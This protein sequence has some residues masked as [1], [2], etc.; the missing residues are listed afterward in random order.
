MP[1]SFPH[2]G[3]GLSMLRGTLLWLSQCLDLGFEHPLRK[4]LQ[5]KLA[6]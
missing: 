6:G 5:P 4:L 3:V 1:L 2:S